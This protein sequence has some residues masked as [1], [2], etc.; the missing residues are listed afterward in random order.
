MSRPAVLC[1]PPEIL[2]AIFDYIRT[3]CGLTSIQ[4]CT[5]VC[6]DFLPYARPRLVSGSALRL[7][8]V[9]E[10]IRALRLARFAPFVYEHFD[11]LAI[12][13][14]IF[15]D[16]LVDGTL[17]EV[18]ETRVLG[19]KA[20]DLP[21][22]KVEGIKYVRW[23]ELGCLK[24]LLAPLTRVKTLSIEWM[25]PHPDLLASDT[26]EDMIR[27]AKHVEVLT[28]GRSEWTDPN[29]FVGFLRLFPNLVS[30]RCERI[31][32]GSPEQP[33]ESSTQLRLSH[34]ALTSIVHTKTVFQ[35]F[36]ELLDPSRL[37]TLE[38]NC[39]SALEEHKDTF[40]NFLSRL[41]PHTITIIISGKKTDSDVKAV[42]SAVGTRSFTY[43][44]KP[45]Q[46]TYI[47]L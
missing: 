24:Q 8:S 10:C 12:Y 36:V 46:L 14:K 23:H 30:V 28:I 4:A 17:D 47:M 7:T 9:E 37:K 41:H 42:T 22:E 13:D 43:L 32:V 45:S 11:N 21:V 18:E 1:Q 16:D 5:L 6:S 31:A 40:F 15:V 25:A 38:F 3:I 29:A 27:I 39:E 26:R 2:H 35:T 20:K 33:L 19:R 44:H 34:V